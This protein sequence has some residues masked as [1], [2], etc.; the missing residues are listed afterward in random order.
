[1]DRIVP[2]RN[3]GAVGGTSAMARRAGPQKYDPLAAYLAAL[4][5]DAVTLT[6]AEIEAIIGTALPA[7]ALGPSFWANYGGNYYAA[8]GWLAVGWRV[9]TLHRT[10]DIDAVTFVRVAPGATA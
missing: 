3:G 5:V 9:A 4:R 6:F 2:Q 7:T 10:L 8:R 1:M